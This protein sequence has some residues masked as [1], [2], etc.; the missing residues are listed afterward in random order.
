MTTLLVFLILRTFCL[1][2]VESAQR[3]CHTFSPYVE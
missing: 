3:A 1:S 2:F